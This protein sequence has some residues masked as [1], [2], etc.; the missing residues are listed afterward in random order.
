MFETTV[1]AVMAKAFWRQ[2]SR[3]KTFADVQERGE[4]YASICLHVKDHSKGTVIWAPGFRQDCSWLDVP[5][6]DRNGELKH[7]RGVVDAPG[8]YVLGLP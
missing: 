3:L 4:L 7:D 6:F 2:P 1:C 5:V 8:L